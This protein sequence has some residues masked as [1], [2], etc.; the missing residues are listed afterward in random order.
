M[1]SEYLSECMLILAV[2]FVFWIIIKVKV[3]D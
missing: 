3:T 2:G 1:L